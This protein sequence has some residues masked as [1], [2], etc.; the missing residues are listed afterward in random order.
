LPR[1]HAG[2]ALTIRD[3]KEPEREGTFLI[4]KVNIGYSDSSGFSRK[5][6]LSYKLRVTSSL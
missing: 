2:D 1:T 6:T 4:E 3:S 5:N